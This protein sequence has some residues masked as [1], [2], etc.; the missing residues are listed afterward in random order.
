MHLI[1]GPTQ[2]SKSRIW[3]FQRDYF[4]HVGIDAWRYGKVPHYISSN[5]IVG[6]TYAE[7]VLA[8]LRDLSL[9]GQQTETVY[10]IEL[11]AGH[12]RMCY[13]FFKHF[14]KYYESSAIRLPP[15]CFILSDFTENNLRFWKEH[16]RLQPY[17]EKGWMDLSLF[18]VEN[19]HEIIL[20]YAGINLKS[21]MLQQPLLVVANYLFD[22]IPQDLY[23]VSVDGIQNC[24]I[25]L[26]TDRNPSDIG[27]DELIKELEIEYSYPE[28][29]DYVR[30]EEPILNELL[31]D[32]NQILTDTHIL[33]PHIG[34]KCLERLRMLSTKGLVLLSADKGSHHFSY[35]DHMPAPKII[36]HGSFSLS[37]N[38]HA[39]VQ[40]CE[41]R[42]GL[43][44]L[45]HHQHANIDLVCFLLLPNPNSYKEFIHAH[46]RFVKNYGPDDYFSIKKIL[47]KNLHII[48][49]QDVLAAIRLSG[50]DS[51][52][53]LQMVP[54]LYEILPEIND[55][56]RWSLYQSIINVWD[57][58]FPLGETHDLAFELGN[59]LMKLVFYKEALIFYELSIKIYGKKGST[60]YNMALCLCLTKNFEN[61]RKIIQELR[62]HNPDSQELLSLTERFG[63]ELKIN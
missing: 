53:F 1:E 5:P 38:Y 52:L 62:V 29:N 18:D 60:L 37:V 49:F 43:S 47:Q 41:S 24:L 4:N 51:R 63:D 32:Y 8:F 22:S 23:H 45:P 56:Q 26:K 19:S 54:R 16:P 17:F 57:T 11:G 35:L 7:L 34:I 12:G 21:Q 28:T 20:Q 14:E 13:H 50:Y 6:K 31:E 42:V 36:A 2:F 30:Y 39:F 44:L 33:F 9:K 25:T 55:E 46:D 27:Q 15:F 40:Y 59:L 58:Y 10:L 61:A 3:Q 48:S